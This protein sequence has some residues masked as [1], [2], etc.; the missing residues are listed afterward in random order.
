MIP[1]LPQL[2]RHLFA[3]ADIL[4]GKMD[5]SEFKEYIFGMLFLKRCSD[6]FD[7]RYEHLMKGNL[8]RG[9]S[10]AESKMRAESPAMYADSFFVP[11]LLRFDRVI[12]N[13]PFSQNYSRTGMKF[14][15]RFHYGFCPEGGKKADLMFLQHMLSV[16]RPSGMV[17]TVMPHRV[18][19]R[20]GGSLSSYEALC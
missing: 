5:V 11:E 16:L 8:A 12:T 17:A 4:R 18:L 10:E 1:T 19:F 15:E 2:E 6:V 20:G 13:P 7:E 3:A 14:R 9:R